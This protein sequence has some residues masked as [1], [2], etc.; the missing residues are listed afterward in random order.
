MKAPA[1]LDDRGKRGA[2][3]SEATPKRLALEA[4]E[5]QPAIT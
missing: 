4:C 3:R 1:R 5:P 2:A